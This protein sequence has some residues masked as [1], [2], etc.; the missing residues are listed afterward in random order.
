MFFCLG[1]KSWSA[2]LCSRAASSLLS[3]LHYCQLAVCSISVPALEV[4]LPQQ[5]AVGLCLVP[6]N[7]LRDGCYRSRRKHMNK[8]CVFNSCFLGQNV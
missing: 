2:E 6:C 3:E 7:S 1:D 4:A 8:M 5:S